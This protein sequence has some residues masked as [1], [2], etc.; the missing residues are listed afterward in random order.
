MRTAFLTGSTNDPAF[1]SG[2]IDVAQVVAPTVTWTR[3]EPKPRR[4]PSVSSSISSVTSWGRVMKY[5]A[6]GPSCSRIGSVNE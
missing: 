1:V 3:T 4:W 6:A 5:H 2:K